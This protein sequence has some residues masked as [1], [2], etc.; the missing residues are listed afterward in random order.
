[1]SIF[2]K[3]ASKKF[4][5]KGISN[6]NKQIK[7][8]DNLKKSCENLQKWEVGSVIKLKTFQVIG[9]INDILL[10][11]PFLKKELIRQRKKLERKMK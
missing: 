10:A 5:K 6:L 4:Y 3:K 7:C 9:H 1:M 8:M 11:I 2:N